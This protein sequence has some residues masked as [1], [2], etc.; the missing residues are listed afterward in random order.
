MK[1]WKG[2]ECTVFLGTAKKFDKNKALDAATKNT[3][4]L[5]TQ[6]T[7]KIRESGILDRLDPDCIEALNFNL[8]AGRHKP[9]V[10]DPGEHRPPSE[11]IK[12]LQTIHEEVQ[13]R[14]NKLSA[15]IE[16]E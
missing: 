3:R 14:L 4:A 5:G 16:A 6:L 11:I 15:L 8:S 2:N 9:F 10:F 13:M 12:E 1:S 7:R